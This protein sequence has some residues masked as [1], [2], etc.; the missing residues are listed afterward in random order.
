M[1]RH[2]IAILGIVFVLVPT[3]ALAN[4]IPP[5]A[6]VVPLRLDAPPTFLTD[7]P[8]RFV[9]NAQTGRAFSGPL[10]EVGPFQRDGRRYIVTGSSIYGF[11]VVDVTDPA[12]PTPVSEYASAF[13]CP[14]SPL[15]DRR[16][17]L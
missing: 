1:W 8:I 2:R 3:S 12:A 5:D 11:S 9:S 10:G 13:G 17:E 16:P 7:G 14:T 15:E 4:H 6:G